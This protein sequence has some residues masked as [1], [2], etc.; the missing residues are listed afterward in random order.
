MRELLEHTAM[1]MAQPQPWGAFHLGTAFG[2]L[3]LAALLAWIL[4]KSGG[5][6][7]DRILLSAG[8]FLCI[9]ETYKQL[10]HTYYLRNGSY[11]WWY[12]P[13]QLCSVPMY[14]CV[15]APLLPAGRVKSALYEFLGTFS[16]MGG[17]A[18]F[19]D[20]P[21]MFYSF[22][23]L[24]LHS[25]IWHILLIFIGLLLGFSGIT[26]RERDA[27]RGAAVLYLALAALALSLNFLLWDRAKGNIDLFYLGPMP[28]TQLFFGTVT[29]LF[30]WQVNA[31]VYAACSILGA[32]LFHTLF[33]ANRE[34]SLVGV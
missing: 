5:E 34:R 8:I 9:A 32:F 27:F 17:I 30:G 12:F 28:S 18:V 6:V 1:R 11:D 26:A 13:L 31:A 24:T 10:F 4:R 3:A 33:R 21:G 25:V 14:L 19:L 15:I 23:S 7:I 20:P 29:R 16:L 22:W 2:G